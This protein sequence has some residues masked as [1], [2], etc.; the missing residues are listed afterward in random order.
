MR[1]FLDENHQQ[2]FDVNYIWLGDEQDG[3]SVLD[4]ATYYD[5]RLKQPDRSPEWQLYYSSN[6]VTELMQEG[7]TQ[8]LAKR[9]G[10]ELLF[11]VVPAESTI[12]N[13][14]LWRFGFDS[15]PSLKF[16]APQYSGDSDSTLD[17]AARFVLDELGNEFEYPN[18][19]SLDPI[20]ERFGLGFP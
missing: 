19:N 3:F 8:F 5:T 16:A 9:P 6:A 1:D 4:F 14:L 7:D 17:F 15:Q 2:K 13:Q 12:E 20:I 10:S 11:I 18:A